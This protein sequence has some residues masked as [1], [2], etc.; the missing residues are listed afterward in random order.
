MNKKS[1]KKITCFFLVLLTLSL[2]LLLA[3]C[4]IESDCIHEWSEW[5]TVTA[6]TC[7]SEGAKQRICAKCE[8]GETN[9]ISATGA[10]TF[11]EWE[12]LSTPTYELDGLKQRSCNCGTVE[13]IVL[14]CV[15]ILRTENFEITVPM[16]SYMV[17]SDYHEWVNIYQSTGYMQYIKGEGGDALNPFL[18]LREQNYSKKTDAATGVTT[19]VTWFDYFANRAAVSVKQILVLCEQA[20]ALGI[21][22][23]EERLEEIDSVM[24]T[25]E[26]FA[27]YSG[28]TPSDYIVELYGK[29]VSEK[30]VRAM[31][32]LIKL[33]EKTVE[34]KTTD[35]EQAIT[36]ERLNEYYESHKTD[37]D[38][39]VD[40][41]A[42]TFEA[43]FV[44]VD[45]T[46][47]DA[48]IKNE[49]AYNKYL[50]DKQKYEER[51][52]ALANCATAKEFCDLLTEYLKQDGATDLEAATKLS[53]IHHFNYEK[54]G[55][56]SALESWIFDTINPV[57]ANDTHTKIKTHNET[58]TSY[59][60]C[61][62]LKPPH[63]DEAYL[64]N[65]GHIL[66][67]TETFKNL[68]NAS[69][70]TGKTK[71][72]A[73]SLLDK[74]ETISAENMAKALVAL[75]IEEGNLITKTTEDGKTYYYMDKDAFKAYGEAYTE[76][77]N[78][79]YEEVKRGYMV[80]AFDEWLYDPGRI[81]N[82]VS[83]VAVKTPYGYHVM[84]YD[85]K[86]Q[87]MNWVIKATDLI[88]TADYEAWY[89]AVEESTLIDLE[90]YEKNINL[91]S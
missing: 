47:I 42:Y 8:E 19:T 24:K 57:K 87:Q 16:M 78:V 41:I 53:E 74:G 4:D 69:S 2:A 51:I 25:I 1:Q 59:T 12:T 89:A 68:K 22:L 58:K 15:G 55:D 26:L 30:D 49:E 62:V 10:H 3:S 37:F 77:S 45:E 61:F 28:Y 75:M 90:K 48:A 9:K 23:D 63:K 27:G 76:D 81:T 83:P 80:D 6:A 70:L 39:Y 32:E 91:I 43:E 40:F 56:N 73:Q 14:P 5:E 17:Y 66:F 64:Q 84:F 65:V 21:V 50:A 11:G 36:D 67:K 71:E 86:A 33:A 79:F 34:C 18:P 52:Q 13:S 82:E 31:L 88:I 85:G 60:V 20:R 72:L 35:F 29:G 7:G 46:E 54:N 38:L 44:P